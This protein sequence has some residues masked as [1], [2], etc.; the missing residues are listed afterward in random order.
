MK[1]SVSSIAKQVLRRLGT[2]VLTIAAL[3]AAGWLAF[4]GSSAIALRADETPAKEERVP[5]Q[6][7][8]ERIS[9]EDGY[10]VAF[11]YR[12]RVE[13][14]QN[15][16][17]GFEAGGT[18]DDVLVNE[19]D[20]VAAGDVLA[21]LDTRTLEAQRD[22]ELAGRDAL[23]AQVELARR[24]AERQR[25]LAERDFASAQRLDEAELSLARLTAEVRRAEA[26]IATLD[27]AIEKSQLLAPFDAVIG[28]RLADDGA[29]LAPGQA[30]FQLFDAAPPEF[31]IGLPA[32]VAE[33]LIPGNTV[34]VRLGDDM[35]TGTVV[36]RRSDIDAATRT[37]DVILALDGGDLS[38]GTLGTVV[39]P[40]RFEGAGAWV[41]LAAL[42][43]GVRGLW[44]LFVVEDGV[45][46][47]EAVELLHMS[48]DRAFVR[49]HLDAETDIVA[50]APH[51]IADGQP[52]TSEAGS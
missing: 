40:R 6:V 51:R 3:A 29:R 36:R 20:V 22:A 25:A 48:G 5:A 10:E 11:R 52:V 13:A 37:R 2:L 35:R 34:E 17:I 1:Q 16:D 23:L 19:G 21:V 18:V 47:R 38:D 43:E 33:T 26:S 50:A 39:L 14:G 42:S 12:G 24:T 41:P 31:R 46:R 44:T 30:V 15:V 28:S 4:S 7:L 9:V 49:G 45:A 32:A 27:V 8:T